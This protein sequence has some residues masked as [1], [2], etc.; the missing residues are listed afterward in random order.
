MQLAESR[1]LTWTNFWSWLRSPHAIA[2]GGLVLF[3]TLV[4][5]SATFVFVNLASAP[6]P[7][8]MIRRAR[9]GFT[10]DF[11]LDGQG[12]D[13]VE[14]IGGGGASAPIGATQGIVLEGD[15]TVV[16]LADR[17]RVDPRDIAAL[18]G[19]PG[20]HRFRSGFTVTVPASEWHTSAR[21]VD[22]LL[23]PQL[24]GWRSGT[25]KFPLDIVFWSEDPFPLLK[26]VI[27]NHALDEP[28]SFIAEFEIYS[29]PV[30]PRLDAGLLRLQGSFESALNVGANPHLLEEDPDREEARWYLLRILGN[31]GNP[32]Y[33]SAAEI[34]LFSP[35]PEPLVEPGGTGG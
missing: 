32:E 4:I 18:N 20:D 27:W 11:S 35:E 6:L 2:L 30:D 19:V 5:G 17:L 12:I 26:V 22:G 24:P 31:H 8:E 28:G 9:V 34:G 23:E 3:L 7:Y 33:V 13:L 15:A 1:R 29:S 21:L 25:A 16:G 10:Q 14:T